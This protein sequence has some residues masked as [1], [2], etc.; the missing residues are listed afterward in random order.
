MD[1]DD[2]AVI[3]STR[4]HSE[5][6][7]IITVLTPSHGRHAGL[8]HGGTSRAQ[9][10]VIQPGNR[11]RAFWHGRLPEQLGTFR[12]ELT[13]AVAARVLDRPG[14]LTALS[15]ACSLTDLCLPERDAHAPVFSALTAL[16]AALD[17]ESWPTVLIHWE[18][19]L[20]RALGFGLDLSVCAVTGTGEDLV[21]V[22][23][24]SGRAVSRTVGAAY[25]DK[26]LPLPLFLVAGGEG[27]A[28]EIRAGLRLTG[29][30]LDRHVL[31]PQHRVMPAARTRLVDL[32]RP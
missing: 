12:L 2:D 20:L 9:R 16:L 27:G 22:S 23:P 25:A 13:D 26:L 7:A 3:L 19:A 10:G 28:D 24:K 14:P 15:A 18:L 17:S 5:N 1:W 30:F 21:W 4:R 11:V 6:A 32:F 31:S 8:V 29:Y